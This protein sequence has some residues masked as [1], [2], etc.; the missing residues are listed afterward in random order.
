MAG[1]IAWGNSLEDWRGVWVFYNQ[2]PTSTGRRLWREA[3][4]AQS[5][6]SVVGNKLTLH[7]EGWFYFP[8]RCIC[9]TDDYLLK[10]SLRPFLKIQT[11][12]SLREIPLKIVTPEWLYLINEEGGFFGVY[13]NP[14]FLI[15]RGALG[16]PYVTD[17]LHC[18]ELLGV[19]HTYFDYNPDFTTM[20]SNGFVTVENN[21]LLLRRSGKEAL[22]QKY[23]QW[24]DLIKDLVIDYATY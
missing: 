14:F 20:R 2:D 8:S 3:T 24:G 16:K 18:W 9:C 15:E 17:W 4:E 22:C 10:K 23:P 7:T 5:L 19:A 11:P 21:N 1:I 13:L 12:D 6:K